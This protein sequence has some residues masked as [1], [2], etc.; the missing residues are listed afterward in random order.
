MATTLFQNGTVVDGSGFDAFK[1]SVLIEKDRIVSV[2]KEGE[3][4]PRAETTI[5]A[6]GLV[7]SP[8]FIDMHSHADW[9]LPTPDHPKNLACMLEQGVTTV[10]GGNCGISPAPVLPESLENIGNLETLATIAMAEKFDYQW[11]TMGEY[12][13]KAQEMKPIVNL[14]ELVGHASV[15]Y[16]AAETLRGQMTS[17]E[18]ERCL[19]QTRQAL[20]EG[21]CGLSF[22]LGYDPGMYSPLDELDA[23][24]SVAAEAN[25]P[26]TVHLKALS[27]ISPTYPLLTRG[28]HNVRS[29]KEMLD[30]ARRTGCKLQLSHFI[31][32]GRNSWSTAPRCLEMVEKARQEGV[33][34]KID[35]YPFT[36]GNTFIVAPFPYWFLA[37][38]EKNLNSKVAR[39]RLRVEFGVGLKLVGFVY[40]DFQVMDAAVPGWEDLNG[41]RIT[42]IAEKWKLSPFE[43]MLTM[44]KKSNGA[45]L[46]LFHTYSGEPENEKVL[47]SV[48]AD[49]NCLFE[50]DVVI[51][52][53]GYPNPAGIGNFPKIL[54]KYVREKKLFSLENAVRRMTAASAERFGLQDVGQLKS[55]LAADLVLFDAEKISDSPGEGRI[56]DS[57]PKGI[58]SVYLN[59]VQAV[60]EGNY[61]QDVR[62]GKVLKV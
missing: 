36:C 7:I 12:L 56:P 53:S 26:V 57:Q 50:T 15:R 23:F 10:V 61:I 46:M 17:R 25:K 35:A 8:G 48:L 42:E 39:M 3:S 2:I 47:E 34:V 6:Q 49:E 24:C 60:K 13:D 1:G 44:A 9:L 59:G 19:D 55:G 54:G 62:A 18:L 14:A 32:V 52:G 31:F 43:T 45:T 30:V 33:D 11:K 22:G 40:K 20:D 51:K 21:A 37:D 27:K 5:D 58:H 29:L 28:A 38:M 16:S 41:L 4:L